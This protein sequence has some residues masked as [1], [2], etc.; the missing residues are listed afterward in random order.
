[1]ACAA[2]MYSTS[3]VE[4]ATV[5]VVP[6]VPLAHPR[7]GASVQS[8]DIAGGGPSRVQIFIIFSIT[9]SNDNTCIR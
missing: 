1:M 8:E 4:T 7:H 6:T 5:D 9:K 3:V 2:A